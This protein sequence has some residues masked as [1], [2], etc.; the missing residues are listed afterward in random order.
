[1]NNKLV[2]AALVA[3]FAVATVAAV[4]VAVTGGDDDTVAGPDATTTTTA[5]LTPV[6]QDLVDRLAAVR[7]R[8]LHLVYSGNLAAAPDGGM[9]TVEVWWKGDR[10][11]QSVLVEAPERRQEQTSFVLPGG[12]IVCQKADGADWA[13]QKS[14]SVATASGRPAGILESLVSQLNGKQVTSAKAKVGDT[15]ADCYTLDQASSDQ[16]CLREDDVPVRFTLSGSNLVVSTVDESVDD[17]VF[18]PPAEPTAAQTAPTT[19]AAVATTTG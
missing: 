3:V 4:V 15:E 19:T 6:A 13:C 8:T 18:T 1:M 14:A 9:V 2:A 10:A 16:L 7:T 17:A 12:N 5:A 11:R